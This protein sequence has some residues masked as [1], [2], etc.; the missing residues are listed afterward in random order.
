LIL[1]RGM[2]RQREIAVRGALGASRWRIIRQLFTE[3]LLLSL[4][5]ATAG[6]ALAQTAL[7]LFSK[8]LSTKL[9][10][11]EHLPPNPAV[12]A[13]LFAL[14]AL[15][16]L[17]FGFFPAWLAARSPIEHSLRQGS[18][19]AGQS[20]GRH[21]VQQGMVVVE[22]GLS[23]VLL[24]GCGLLLRTV[25]A[26]RRVPLG[27]R[28]DHVLL[29]QPQVPAYKFR[30]V[31]VT[32][33][34]YRPLL[35][36][37]QRMNG[38][39]AASLTTVVPLRKS[40]QPKITLNLSRPQ[41]APAPGEPIEARLSA[42]GPELQ[43]VL[44]FRIYQG[45]FF[46]LQDTADSPPVVVVNRAFANW[47]AP[48][49]DII[50]HFNVGFGFKGRKATVVGV[51]DD[52]HQA[53]IDRPSM[54]EIDFCA[55]QLRE[56]DGFY[57]PTMQAHIEL[58]VRTTKEPAALIPD[59]RRVMAE[60]NPD[61][62]AT[63]IDTMDQVVEDSLGS[64]LLAAH[65]LELFAGSAL[66]VA[67]AGLY[68]LLT[69]LVTQ[70][71]QELGI[72]MALGAQRRNIIEM[73]LLQAGRL[74]LAGAALG[75]GLAYSSSRVLAGFLYGVTPHDARSFLAVT[76]VLLFCGLAAAYIPARRA[77]R[78]DPIEALRGE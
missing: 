38:I 65:L 40:F 29:L 61:L 59:L 21:R 26:L 18:A 9:N 77:S 31:D 51:M 78:V 14:S 3:S 62:Q 34:I 76:A 24:V 53:S 63:K 37:V 15:S 52:F 64:Q 13:A 49:G 2:A 68:G 47:Y 55:S 56:G 1:A 20:R 42:A 17:L 32:R 54:P 50:G 25:F 36:R 19:R 41:G 58:A 10:L 73:L 35:E 60:V 33:A 27:F 44:G 23:L 57:Q 46:S 43:D 69:Y 71:T 66:L 7:Y 30:G 72:R 48:D 6:L 67:L 70:R 28:T 74:L 39:Q 75:A 45:R 12:L 11:P 22:I 8:T 5:G 16:A 4:A